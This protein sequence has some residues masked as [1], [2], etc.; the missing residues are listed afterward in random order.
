MHQLC[1]LRAPTLDGPARVGSP[2][3][4]VRPCDGAV[5]R[6]GSSARSTAHAVR[7]RWLSTR[8]RPSGALAGFTSEGRSMVGRWGE[9]QGGKE[10]TGCDRLTYTMDHRAGLRRKWLQAPPPGWDTDRVGGRPSSLSP[11]HFRPQPAQTGLQLPPGSEPPAA[12]NP[13]STGLGHMPLHNLALKGILG[14]WRHTIL[15]QVLGL[16]VL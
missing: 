13:P 7:G 4:P 14:S 2:T 12:Q 15:H 3:P 9:G 1:V 11:G 5:P 10:E 6:S 16:P 8:A